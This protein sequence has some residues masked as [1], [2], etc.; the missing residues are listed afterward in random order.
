[1]AAAALGRANFSL[2]G[3]EKHG[4]ESGLLG[5]VFTFRGVGSLTRPTSL[6]N[7]LCQCHRQRYNATRLC[8][9]RS[10]SDEWRFLVP[11]CF[12]EFVCVGNS[13]RLRHCSSVF[14]GRGRLRELKRR[15]SSRKPGTKESM[16]TKWLCGSLFSGSRA[17]GTSCQHGS[18]R[19]VRF[20]V[21]NAAMIYS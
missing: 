7:R 19:N 9:T 2:F 10:T 17:Y 13:P 4:L 8:L 14:L 21:I 15:T 5:L 18:S 12:W 6:P 16:S 1:M 3:W 20:W 11:P